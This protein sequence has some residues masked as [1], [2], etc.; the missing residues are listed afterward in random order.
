MHRHSLLMRSLLSQSQTPTA[1]RRAVGFFRSGCSTRCPA[2]LI[3]QSTSDWLRFI[4]AN[5][6]DC[7]RAA[8][9][10]SSLIV[11]T[12]AFWCIVELRASM[13]GE[14][15]TQCSVHAYGRLRSD[16]AHLSR[17]LAA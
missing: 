13:H 2:E 1:P 12:A 7:R 4:S 16:L 14:I 9:L 17:A 8:T 11:V 6:F 10:K 3:T 15:A 5:P